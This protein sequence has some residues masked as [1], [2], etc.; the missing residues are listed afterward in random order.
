MR[1]MAEKPSRRRQQVLLLGGL[2]LALLVTVFFGVRAFR[3]FSHPPSNEPIREWMNLP[4]I[5]HAY[6]V[7]PSVLLTALGLPADT[8]PSRRP[9]RRIAQDLNLTTA[10]VITRLEEAIAQE[11][12]SRAPPGEPSAKPPREEPAVGPPPA[13]PSAP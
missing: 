4:Y 6:R 10:D 9:I 1:S 3:R 13:T 12:S 2:L 8:P 7:P 11:R 5:A